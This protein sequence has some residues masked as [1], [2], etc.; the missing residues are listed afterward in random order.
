MAYAFSACLL[1]LIALPSAP[2]GEDGSAGQDGCCALASRLGDLGP[3]VLLR[4]HRLPHHR[5]GTRVLASAAPCRVAPLPCE[6]PVLRVETMAHVDELPWFPF[7]W[8]RWRESKAGRTASPAGR[9]AYLE[10]MIDQWAD[11]DVPASVKELAAAARVDEAAIREILRWW[12]RV[13]GKARRRLNT[14]M[15]EIRQEQDDKHRKRVQAGRL[16]GLAKA[17]R[18]SSNGVE[19]ALPHRDQELDEEALRSSCNICAE[20]GEDCGLVNPGPDQRC[21]DCPRGRRRAR[22]K[23]AEYERKRDDAKRP[24]GSGPTAIGDILDGT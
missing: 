6:A 9:C 13:P 8:R 5:V 1:L 3:R 10:L 19:S 18:R 12:P 4:S 20:E 14:Q 16:G 23:A 21:C 7:Y 22:D 11:G 15:L 2:R 17:Q 24:R